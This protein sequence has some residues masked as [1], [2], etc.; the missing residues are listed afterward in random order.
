MGGIGGVAGVAGVAGIMFR[1]SKI[2]SVQIDV[3]LKP[4]DEPPPDSPQKARREKNTL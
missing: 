2:C 3:C 4:F 1:K